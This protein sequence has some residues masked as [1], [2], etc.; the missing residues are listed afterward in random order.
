MTIYEQTAPCKNEGVK[1]IARIRFPSK[2]MIL[3][4]YND[5]FDL[6]KGDMVYVEG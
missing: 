4:Y 3:D 2:D 1:S 6:Q 5:L